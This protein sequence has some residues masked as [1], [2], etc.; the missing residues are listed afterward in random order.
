MRRLHSNKPTRWTKEVFKS[1]VRVVISLILVILII[2]V[3]ITF[4]LKALPLHYD[5]V[6]GVLDLI[7][8]IILIGPALYFLV[9]RPMLHFLIRSTRLQKEDQVL[10]EIAEGVTST[11]NLG[12]L[13]ELMHAAI[14]KVL[15]AEN[16][17]FALYDEKKQSFNFPYFI[18]KYDQPPEQD[19]PLEKSCTAYVFRLGKSMLIPGDAFVKLV[20]AGEVELVGS[21]APSWIGITLK[22]SSKTIGVLVLQHYE[23]KNVYD[24]DHLRFLDS[25]AS[26]VANVIERKRAEEELERSFSLLSATLEA[27]ADGIMVVDKNR[28]II[29]FNRKFGEL[30]NIPESVLNDHDG[31]AMMAFLTSQVADPAALRKIDDE[32]YMDEEKTSSDLVECKDGRVFER[33]SQP[34]RAE[35]K[36]LGRVWSYRDITVEREAERELRI[37][38]ERFRTIFEN[39]PIGIELYDAKGIQVDINKTALEIFGI[40][41]KEDTLGFD[42]FSGTSL[43]PELKEK[44]S[45]GKHIDYKASFDFTKVKKLNQYKTSKLGISELQYSITPLKSD[46][47]VIL[48]YLVLIQDITESKRASDLLK[49]NEARLRKLNAS[50]DKFFSIIAHD[51]KNPFNA[52]VGFSDL[53]LQKIHEK[54]YDGVEE[55]ADLI[56]KS[57]ERIMNLLMN[58]LEWARS[59][60]G[61]VKAKPELIAAS[62]IVGEAIETLGNLAER[63]S[64]AI[65][66]EI[67]DGDKIYADRA[68]VSTVVRNLL[69]NAIKFTGVGG[70]IVISATKDNGQMLFKVSDT[71]VGMEK[72][73]MEKLFRIDESLSMPGTMDER[74][75]GLGLL[76][77]KEFIEKNGGRIWAES[78]PG[79]GSTFS[80]TLPTRK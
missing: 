13:L 2:D 47:G 73:A 32:I 67:P 74:G 21:N 63:K 19:L 20:D 23:K 29:H 30:W 22:T 51:L 55:L 17:F 9:F 43:T 34:Q 54:D 61:R 10:Y 48:S 16:C 45:Q 53:L 64:I 60:T 42:L 18:D 62:F 6:S 79:K 40:A 76:I 66:A 72:K 46:E 31:K 37:S 69:S 77:C 11:S 24:E 52:I 80:F 59:Q 26:Q 7:I 15:Y 44:L 70:K 78:E 36:I 33:Y 75:T 39:S 35:G 5:R 4:L 58:L 8:L 3:G 27:T 71:G 49:E 25:I 1:P 38:E 41:E 50:K 28:E 12:E 68:M 56:K 57:A 14:S 65:S